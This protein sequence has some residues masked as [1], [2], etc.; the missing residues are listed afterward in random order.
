[1]GPLLAAPTDEEVE[2]CV[3]GVGGAP[4][5]LL[6][7]PP[8]PPLLVLPP[9]SDLEGNA[10]SS[11]S[12]SGSSMASSPRQNSSSS[13]FSTSGR[14]RLFLIRILRFSRFGDGRGLPGMAYKQQQHCNTFY[15]TFHLVKLT[16]KFG[17]AS[18]SSISPKIS[19]QYLAI[20]HCCAL[21]QWF[22]KLRMMG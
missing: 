7:P 14:R 18:V 16:G 3:A 20:L 4:P 8:P 11:C 17:R 6:P 21:L 13:C 5:P 19:T 15:N 22:S 9:S 1:M 10:A 2:C 12:S